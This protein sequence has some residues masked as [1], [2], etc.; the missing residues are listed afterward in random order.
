MDATINNVKLN[1]REA[2]EELLRRDPGMDAELLR[3]ADFFDDDAL[4]LC[5]FR[6]PYK[7]NVGFRAA[8]THEF[9]EMLIV[10]GGT[11]VHQYAG[12]TVT[13][14]RGDLF[15]IPEGQRHGYAMPAGCR[16]ENINLLFDLSALGID[17]D[18]LAELNGFKNV[19]APILE[20][21]KNGETAP[22]PPPLHLSPGVLALVSSLINSLENELANEAEGYRFF[23]KFYFSKVIGILSRV[24]DH[25]PFREK[26]ESGELSE[27][28]AYL[29]ENL[30]EK[31]T[32][33]DM[34]LFSRISEGSL[35]NKFQEVYAESPVHYL[36][37]I[38]VERSMELLADLSLTVTD[39]AFEVGMSDSNYYSRIFRKVN[40]CSPSEY[41]EKLQ[42][43][44]PGQ[45]LKT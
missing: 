36:Q 45:L 30:S 23:A 11:A 44:L 25:I 21:K 37:R 18:D 41:R 5:V 2:A 14:K 35:R 17:W 4:P 6:M 15:L 10:T 1:K 12:E 34:A 26:T 31:I 42:Q 7:F 27:L 29:E 40:G 3:R 43:D 19:F 38:R 32:V 24:A 9:D 13:V 28:A 8:H 20:A 16:M 22:F 39:I 33:T